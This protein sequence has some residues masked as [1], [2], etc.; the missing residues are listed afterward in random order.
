MK[1]LYPRCHPY[2]KNE[3]GDTIKNNNVKGLAVS[4]DDFLLPCC[5]LDMTDRDN[6]INGITY[7]RREHLKIQNNDSIDDIVN[8]EEWK[9]FHRV[10]LE[11]PYDAPERCKTKCSKPLPK[12][13]G[14]E[15]R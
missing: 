14:N 8:S 7:M 10:L 4:A 1:K 12:G 13:A 6:K 5:W 2:W 15:I 11:A 3:D 9:H